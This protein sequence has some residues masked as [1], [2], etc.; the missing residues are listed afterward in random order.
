MSSGRTGLTSLRRVVISGGPT[1]PA[2]SDTRPVE[3]VIFGSSQLYGDVV[4]L[5]RCGLL[6]AESG[7]GQRRYDDVESAV[8]HLHGLLEARQRTGRRRIRSPAAS[9]RRETRVAP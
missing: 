1:A 5:H 9:S 4:M 2:R 6:A 8:A 3:S 7:A